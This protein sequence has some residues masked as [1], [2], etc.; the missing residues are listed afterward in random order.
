MYKRWLA[1]YSTPMNTNTT[2]NDT[3]TAKPEWVEQDDDYVY[4][5]LNEYEDIDEVIAELRKEVGSSWFDVYVD[6]E[7]VNTGQLIQMKEWVETTY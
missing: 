5:V 6:D 2:N 3:P 4:A 7:Y 1:V